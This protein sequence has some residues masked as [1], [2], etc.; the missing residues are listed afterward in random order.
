MSWSGRVMR[1]LQIVTDLV[2][3][4]LLII[5]GIACGLGVFGLMPALV[6][7]A[8]VLRADR[9][10]G[11]VRPFLAAYR[12][13]FRDA[14]LAGSPFGF[15]AV[16]IVADAVVIPAL[17]GPAGAVL[18]VLTGAVAAVTVVSASLTVILLTRYDDRPLAVARFGLVLTLVSPGLAAAVLATLVA[19]VAV[20]LVAPV[21][22]PLV[23]ASL[24]LVLCCRLIDRSLER[25][26]AARL[27]SLTHQG[28]LS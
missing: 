27:P 13:R 20:M 6:A 8:T 17:P 28:V 16:L 22:A 12:G 3:I 11:I 26:G 5:A 19:T 9:D 1:M 4:N 18:L 21:L 25:L 24:P 10:A 15:A 2:L 23:G 7:G 14:N